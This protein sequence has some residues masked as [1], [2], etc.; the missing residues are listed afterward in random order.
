MN[1]KAQILIS[2]MNLQVCNNKKLLSAANYCPLLIINQSSEEENNFNSN[3]LDHANISVFSFFERGLSKSRNRAIECASAD[4][5]FIADD[6]MWYNPK[7]VQKIIDEFEK[8]PELDIACF[9]WQEAFRDKRKTYPEKRKLLD[10]KS[11][12]HFSSIEIAFRLSSIR[13]AGLRFNESFGLG[14]AF[15]LS[16]ELIFL[17]ESQKKNLKAV[18]FPY[19]VVNHP[20]LSSGS[21][22]DA[23]KAFAYGGFLSWRYG[24]L[25]FPAALISALKKYPQYKNQDSFSSY[26]FSLWK[27]ILKYFF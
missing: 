21:Q 14:A 24:I 12:T 9:I 8:D 5:C 10:K 25:A 17:L 13:K 15:P 23:K 19:Q 7:E 3:T 1:C 22:L 20:E 18:F 16:E 6:D 27:G 2:T 26:L 11:I 4:I